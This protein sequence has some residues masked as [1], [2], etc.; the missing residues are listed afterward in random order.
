M[1]LD[2][3]ADKSVEE[4]CIFGKSDGKE[5]MN[6]EQFRPMG[7]LFSRTDFLHDNLL[8]WSL[9]ELYRPIQQHRT[10]EDD[11]SCVVSS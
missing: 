7:T 1:I 10:K 5:E 9:D 11:A 8:G 6:F 2:S 3:S 4:F